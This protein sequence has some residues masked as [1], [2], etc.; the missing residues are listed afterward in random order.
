MLPDRS[1][2]A[3]AIRPKGLPRR[4]S[5]GAGLPL[6][7]YVPARLRADVRVAPAIEHDAGDI[8]DGVEA[9]PAEHV[10]ELLADLPLVVPE[11]RGQHLRAS[12]LTLLLDRQ[13]W[14]RVDHLQVE[15]DRLVRADRGRVG[16]GDRNAPDLQE[17]AE[18]VEPAASA[19]PEPLEEP[20]VPDGHV[21]HHRGRSIELRV[22]V[23][24]GGRQVAH[25]VP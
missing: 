22:G 6:V 20:P 2:F 25:D 9:G 17:T 13:S 16:A 18:T 1:V 24:L 19:D 8:P 3:N 11:R 12:D 21:R 5:R 7:P 15:D 10:D 14:R 4:T 23:A